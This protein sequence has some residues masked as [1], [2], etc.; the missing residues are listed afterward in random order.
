MKYL[1]K[2]VNQSL[3]RASEDI[4]DPYL[5]MVRQDPVK[6]LRYKDPVDVNEVCCQDAS[7]TYLSK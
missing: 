1:K 2:S 6:L 4:M 7:S 5:H 3:T